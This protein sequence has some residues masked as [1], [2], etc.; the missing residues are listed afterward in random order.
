VAD[1]PAAVA[2]THALLFHA[3]GSGVLGRKA[4]GHFEACERQQAIVY[5]PMAVIWETSL[6]ARVGRV[7]LRRPVRDFFDDLFSNPAYHAVDLTA[8]QVY[9]ADDLRF[10]RDPFDALIAAT[11]VTLKL[12]L[13][14]RDATIR[15]AAVVRV[16][17]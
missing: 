10:T 13:L 6:L 4:A 3:A 5:I 16:I 7:S 12:P 1:L 9:M 8:A 17:W 2:D 15:A 14:T 11:A